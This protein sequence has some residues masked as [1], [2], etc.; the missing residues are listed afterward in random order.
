MSRRQTEIAGRARQ[1]GIAL[2]AALVLMLVLT[3]LAA[4]AME[5]ARIDLVTAGSV[6]DHRVAFERA[7]AGIASALAS[8]PS[9]AAAAPPCAAGPGLAADVSVEDAAG[10]RAWLCLVGRTPPLAGG[11]SPGHLVLWHYEIVA[12]GR[13][14]SARSVH[15]QG[16]WLAA[17]ADGYPP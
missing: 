1:P 8:L 14:G 4:S 15:R 9:Q 7:E 13:H 2:V 5:M 11:T 10:A 3:L 12:E 16:A 6:G 17:P